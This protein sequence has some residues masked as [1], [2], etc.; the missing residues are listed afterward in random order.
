MYSETLY[1]CKELKKKISQEHLGNICNMPYTKC[2]SLLIKQQQMLWSL[3][4]GGALR[5]QG[6]VYFC[7]KPLKVTE[8]DVKI[9]KTKK[10]KT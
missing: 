9:L 3:D 8:K 6:S 2:G 7:P 1:Q 4:R 10:N 5:T